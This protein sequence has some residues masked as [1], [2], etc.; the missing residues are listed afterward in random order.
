MS[1]S[2][3]TFAP[4]QPE[5]RAALEEIV[6]SYYAFDGHIYDPV[7][8]GPALDALA[9][10]APNGYAWLIREGDEIAGYLVISTGFS[11]EYGGCDGF[12]DELYLAEPFRD[13]GL[14]A[15]IMDF[16]E[17]AATGLGIRHLHLEVERHN[18]RARRLYERR[19]YENHDRTL[20]TKRL[21]D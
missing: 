10:G 21:A 8:Q 5:H 16:A 19:G 20:M 6:R 12:I 15:E 11:I 9:T 2:A 4:V 13:R 1:Q 18:K 3:L 14:G 17:R 7:E